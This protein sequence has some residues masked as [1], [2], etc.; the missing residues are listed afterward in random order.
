MAH[1]NSKEEKVAFIAKFLKALNSKDESLLD[2]CFAQD[3]KMTV[4]GTGGR[5]A[6]DIPLP[7][8]IAGSL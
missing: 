3:F 1:T 2:D 8:G 5:E 6:N 4:P 7:P